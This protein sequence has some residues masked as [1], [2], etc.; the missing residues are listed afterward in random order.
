MMNCCA[1]IVQFIFFY[2]ILLKLHPR[3]INIEIISICTFCRKLSS[4]SL[5]FSTK[6]KKIIKKKN[7]RRYE[8]I[9]NSNILESQVNTRHTAPTTHI[10]KF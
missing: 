5:V 7:T 10:Y 1:I 8:N 6:K 2:Y 9:R 3:I 4:T